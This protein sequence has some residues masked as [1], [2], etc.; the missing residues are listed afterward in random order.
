MLTRRELGVFA[1]SALA[2]LPRNARAQKPLNEPGP[3]LDIA[4]WS[5]FWYGVEHALLAR[6]TV[7]NG[8]QMY[9]EHWIPATV[10]HPWPVVLIHGGYGQ[11]SDWIS[12]PDGRRGWA[13]LLSGT[14]LQGL[15]PRSAGQG[16]RPLST[17]G[18][19]LLR[20]AGA[21]VRKTAASVAGAPDDPVVVQLTAS[22]G[23]PMANNPVTQNVWRTRGALL[24]DRIGPA[25][26]I[27]HSDGAIFAWVTA[28]ARPDLVKGIVAVQP[29][30]SSQQFFAK[31]PIANMVLAEP[32]N[33]PMAIVEKNNRELLQPALDW[34]KGVEPRTESSTTS[35][36]DPNRNT[37][38]TALKLADQ[39]GFWVGVQ[40]KSM[41]YGTIAQGQMFVQYMIPAEKRHPFPLSWFTAGAGRALT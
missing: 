10:R 5:Y 3:V 4:D 38:S 20:H 24:L 37:E 33:G 16:P 1:A 21:H 17:L 40:R 11:G 30:A 34:M 13:T 26:L 27:T 28:Q 15:R 19:R 35:G 2:V 8:M 29:S 6:G 31:T 7:C 9:V 18:A 23:Q 14:G 39:G 41:P 36:L 32:G 25:I 12:T 22:M